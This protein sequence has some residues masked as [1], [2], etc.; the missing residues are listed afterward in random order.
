VVEAAAVVVASEGS[1]PLDALPMRRPPTIGLPIDCRVEGT[2]A[3]EVVAV[4]VVEIPF[5]TWVAA[6]GLS[7][8]VLAY[9]VKKQ[10]Y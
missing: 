8:P 6:S 7:S 5:A 10:P 9:V 4:A 2:F 1:T 3:I